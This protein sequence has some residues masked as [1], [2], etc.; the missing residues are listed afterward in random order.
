[1]AGLVETD[2]HC[3]GSRTERRTSICDRFTR[4]CKSKSASRFRRGTNRRSLPPEVVQLI[5][6]RAQARVAKDFR[7]SDELREQIFALGWEV[8]DMKDRAKLTRRA[9]FG[10]AL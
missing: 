7:K 4:R 6:E 10:Y 5:K 9:G 2:Q 3:S 8:R 1:M